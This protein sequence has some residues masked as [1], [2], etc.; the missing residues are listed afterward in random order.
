LSDLQKG[1]SDLAAYNPAKNG[2][3]SKLNDDDQHEAENL[4]QLI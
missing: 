1:V 4:I 2:V 3:M